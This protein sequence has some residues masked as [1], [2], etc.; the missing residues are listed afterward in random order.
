MAMR[1]LTVSPEHLE[2]LHELQARAVELAAAKGALILDGG[3]GTGKTFTTNR[4]LDMFESNGLNIMCA[5][6]TGKAAQRM[7]ELTGREATTIHRMLGW[8]P[9]GWRHNADEPCKFDADGNCIGGPLPTDVVVLDETSM[10]DHVL[11]AGV[12]QAMAPTQRLV[13]IGDVNQL[14]SIG[15]GRVLFDLIETGV[16]PRVTLTKIFR[17][18]DES[19]IP[20]VARDVNEGVCPDVTKLNKAA[21]S[22][23]VAWVDAPEVED[24]QRAIVDAV[25]RF[26]PQQ[27]GIPSEDIQVLCPQ[28]K[29]AIGIEVL[30]DLLQ[31]ELN[32]NFRDDKRQGLRVGRGYRVFE[33]DRVI[34]ANKNDYG[35]MVANGEVGRVLDQNWKGVKVPADA[36]QS[37]KGKPVAIV[38]FGDRK[39]AYTKQEAENLELAYAITIH[40]SQGSQ[41]PCVVMPVHSLNRFSLTRPLVYTAITRTERLLVMLGEPD[42]L[43]TACNN[44]RGTERRTSLQE[45]LRGQNQ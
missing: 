37:G 5:A 36:S 44:T 1:Q 30:N 18:A 42:S 15:K 32:P 29:K 21:G 8:T 13:L 16:V 26:I 24:L 11:F 33:G 38:D 45:R 27:R 41:F 35:I 23:D 43:A 12:L 28:N 6:P 9:F 17:Q 10:I 19:A 20:F 2:G 34:H 14:P 40:K 4:I 22:P 31:R 3:P 7:K 39:V 25:V